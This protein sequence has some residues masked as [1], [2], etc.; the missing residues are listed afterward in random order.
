MGAGMKGVP[1]WLAQL[2]ERARAAYQSIGEEASPLYVKHHIPVSQ[3]LEGRDWDFETHESESLP[4]RFRGLEEVEEVVVLHVDGWPALIRVPEAYSRRGV[5]ALSL[6]EAL[7]RAEAEVRRGIEEGVRLDESRPLTYLVSR[8]NSGALVKVPSGVDEPV[9]VRFVWAGSGRN[10]ATSA[11][12]LVIAGDNTDV[13]VVDEYHSLDGPVL[14]GNIVHV[15]GG[16]GSRV[17]YAVLENLSE[18]SVFVSFSRSVTGNDAHQFWSG[19][20]IGGGKAKYRVDNV[21]AGRG[22][23]A[24]ALEVTMTGGTQMFDVTLNLKHVAPDTVGRVHA[25]GIGG[26]RSRTLFKGIIRIEREAKNTGAYLAEHA[27]LLSPEARAD[28]IP[29]LEIETDNVKATHSA[30]VAQ[31]DP[32]HLFYLMCRGIPREEA[33]K[34][35]AFG[36]FEPVIREIDV[37]EVRWGIRYLLERKWLGPAGED[38]DPAQVMET[39]I[40]PEE[41][42]RRPEDIF[43]THYKAFY[44]RRR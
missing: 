7:R 16:N 1:G 44:Y 27:M 31:I 24:D 6:E 36:F 34:L 12:T 20:L 3:D 4:E 29:G 14:I 39:Y 21:L 30:S 26:G 22:A 9:R 32:E 41:V 43:G 35:I 13:R 25:K 19:A 37:P 8:L 40:E 5:V 33:V 28:A 2:R 11:Y 10:S 38:L 15:L 23:R 42:G 17:R 18:E